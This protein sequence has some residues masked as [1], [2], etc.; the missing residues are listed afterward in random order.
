MENLVHTPAWSIFVTRN[1]KLNNQMGPHSTDIVFTLLKQWPRDQI[2]CLLEPIL[3]VLMLG[4]LR[5]QLA[6]K[7]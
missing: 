1:I 6:A 5:M 4:I 2:Q 7:T 3:V